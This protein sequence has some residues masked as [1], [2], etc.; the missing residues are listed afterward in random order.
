[1]PW[2]TSKNILWSKDLFVQML[3]KKHEFV[4]LISLW[5]Y[6]CHDVISG[7]WLLFLMQLRF[8]FNWFRTVQIRRH[9]PLQFNYFLFFFSENQRTVSWSCENY[10][11]RSLH[12]LHGKCLHKDNWLYSLCI[13]SWLSG[14]ESVLRTSVH[15]ITCN[16]RTADLPPRREDGIRSS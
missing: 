5:S 14:Q 3:L 8:M 1:M 7:E 10:S 15:K 12:W 2:H 16:E 4:V 11:R 13:E 9:L 6:T